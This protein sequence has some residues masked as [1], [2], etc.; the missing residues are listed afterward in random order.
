MR[1][2]PLAILI[3]PVLAIG[4]YLLNI[5]SAT[6][7]ERAVLTTVSSLIMAGRQQDTCLST[8]TK[9]GFESGT[10][11]F[12]RGG[13]KPE[14]RWLDDTA[15]NARGRSGSIYAGRST[16][17][18]SGLYSSISDFLDFCGT[19][20]RLS[21]P[22]F[23][24]NLAFVSART[25]DPVTDWYGVESFALQRTGEGWIV[26]ERMGWNTGPVV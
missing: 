13:Y 21:T 26:I 16:D 12:A 7:E 4:F 1:S 10:Y 14:R 2:L 18:S 6:R 17:A 22:I 23:A 5:P 11:G 25:L 9:P 24:R 3:A 8:W 19:P 15:Q 20:T